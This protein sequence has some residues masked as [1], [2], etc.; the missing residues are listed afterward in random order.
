M[1]KWLIELKY[2]VDFEREMRRRRHIPSTVASMNAAMEEATQNFPNEPCR[3]MSR[4]MSEQIIRRAQG[5]RSH[6]A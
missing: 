5:L 4:A 3:E 1:F 2:L 6:D